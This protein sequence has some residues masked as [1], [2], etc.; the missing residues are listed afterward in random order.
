M[1]NISNAILLNISCILKSKLR[2]SKSFLNIDM[3][4]LEVKREN[5]PQ[6]LR[7]GPMTWEREKCIFIAH[8]SVNDPRMYASSQRSFSGLGNGT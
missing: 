3:L 4:Y 8:I 6:P 1:G 5:C 7:L 2:H